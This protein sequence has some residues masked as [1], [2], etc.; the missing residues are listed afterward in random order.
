MMTLSEKLIRLGV[1]R[2]AHDLPPP[3]TRA[4]HSID[5]VVN[6][7]FRST[8]TGDVFVADT[9]Y[10]REDKHGRV[11]LLPTRILPTIAE[12][13]HDARMA[14]IDPSQLVFL[15]TET[16]GLAGGTGTFA[17]LIGIGRFEPDGF[18]VAQYF[19]RD[20]KEEIAVLSAL[21]SI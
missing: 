19:L 20:P 17:F 3:R 14:E 4:S 18:R 16:T 9:L 21:W 8:T 2:G 12:W 1:R 6:G 10:R 11:D 13:A 7:S 5:Q 15:D